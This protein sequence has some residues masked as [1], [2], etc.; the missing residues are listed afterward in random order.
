MEPSSTTS[1]KRQ[2]FAFGPFEV[3]EAEACLRCDGQPVPMRPKAFALLLHLLENRGR[4]VPTEELH[5]AVW[6]GTAVTPNAM[7]N[8]VGEVRR[9]LDDD[10]AAPRYIETVARRGYR[11]VAPLRD[12]APPEADPPP[13]LPGFVGRMPELADLADALARAGQGVRQTVFLHGEPGVGKTTL[14]EQFVAECRPDLVVRAQ[15][16]EGAGAGDA[17]G[18]VLHALG[19]LARGPRRHELVAMLR[20]HAP[21]WLAQMSWLIDADELQ[22]IQRTLVGV[23]AVRMVREGVAVFEELA[24]MQPLVLLLEDL[25]WSDAATVELVRALAQRTEACRLL[26]IGTYRPVDALVFEHPVVAAVA[27]L[28]RRRAVHVLPLA[29]FSI[30][31]VRA[32]LE[33]QLADAGIAARLAAPIAHHCSGNPLFVQTVCTQL[34]QDG[35]VRQGDDGWEVEADLERFVPRLPEDLR[36]AIDLQIAALSAEGVQLLEAASLAGEESSVATLAAALDWDV[37]RAEDVCHELARRA[38]F[39]RAVPARGG[40]GGATGSVYGFTHALYQRAFQNRVVPSERRRLHARI[41]AHL[42]GI[43]RDHPGEVALRL[44]IHF[45]EAGDRDRAAQYRELVGFVSMQ[46]F[47]HEEAVRSLRRALAHL[48]AAP[49]VADAELRRARLYLT[50]ALALTHQHGFARPQVME[51]FERAEQHAIAAGALRERVRALLGISSVHLGAG[52]PRSAL[53]VVERQLEIVTAQPSSLWFYSHCRVARVNFLLGNFRTALDHLERSRGLPIEPGVPVH[54]DAEAE[55]NA[56]R[57]LT[58][59][60]LGFVDQ[61]C[62]AAERATQRASAS[63][64]AWGYGAVMAIATNA[65]LIRRD[66]RRASDLTADCLAYIERYDLPPAVP[67]TRF[68]EQYLFG[69]EAP[70]AAVVATMRRHLDDHHRFGEHWASVLHW[71]LL[72]DTQLRSGDP[73]GADATLDA[74]FAHSAAGGDVHYLAELWR[75]RG[76][77]ARIRED[78]ARGRRR[79]AGAAESVAEDCFRKAVAIAAGQGAKL[80]ELRAAVSLARLLAARGEA[81]AAVALL[82]PIHVWFTEGRDAADVAEAAALLGELRSGRRRR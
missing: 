21:A 63:G 78:A 82:A 75:L 71:S 60:H 6:R 57:A 48:D 23:G 19:A 53:P 39:L 59:V 42:E 76:E 11:F 81:P 8:V 36:A 40:D 1:R 70:S 67:I 44:A 61:A 17:Y 38:W 47:D 66:Y 32:C 50:L 35:W 14:V 15:C 20:R 77:S 58:L 31:E 2:V 54:V 74:A 80:L 69:I 16:V 5:D 4:L 65:S 28:R 55:S 33:H 22:A 41:G 13:P 27:Q 34:R 45:E 68:V 56:W 10:R 25:H 29:P 51:A 37:D 62:E 3:D 9:A 64:V 12:A 30:S 24:R 79:R 43:H 72:A 26:V 18:P 46:R 49:G 52:D 73:A 7:T